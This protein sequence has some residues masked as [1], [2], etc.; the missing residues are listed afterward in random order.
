MYN[1]LDSS[2]LM[3][4]RLNRAGFFRHQLGLSSNP[5]QTRRSGSSRS[6]RCRRFSPRTMRNCSLE[7]RRCGSPRQSATSGPAATLTRS[8]WRAILM[9]LRW[10]ISTR[11][12]QC[13]DVETVSHH[14]GRR[15]QR[16]PVGP[17]G[18]AGL[19]CTPDAGHPRKLGLLPTQQAP[20]T[21]KNGGLF[22][23]DF[24]AEG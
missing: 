22:S 13:P 4:L 2:I 24:T 16:D 20:L 1:D 21:S 14:F 10:S 3:N 18:P 5:P 15:R 6:A 17:R 8:M 23:R 12:D 9:R 11:R 19:R 7:R